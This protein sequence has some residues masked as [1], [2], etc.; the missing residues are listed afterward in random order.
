M[1][2]LSY[3]EIPILIKGGIMNYKVEST[4]FH[5]LFEEAD[6]LI[7]SIYF[8]TS[9]ISQNLSKNQIKLKNAISTIKE[10]QNTELFVKQLEVIMNDL[11]FWNQVRYG[12]A[13]LM[14][15][16]KNIVHF[17][18]KPVVTK[19]VVDSSPYLVPLIRHYQH[20]SEVQLLLVNRS[21]FKVYRGTV[22]KL[23]L[24]P[25]PTDEP[26]LAKDVLGEEQTQRYFGT[27]PTSVYHGGSNK[28]DEEAIDTVRYFKYVD[29]L[30]LEQYSKQSQLPLILVALPQYH[31]DFHKISEN[32]YLSKD[33]IGSDH[34]NSPVQVLQDE[35]KHLFEQETRQQLASL[36]DRFRTGQAN[37]M[38][39][40]FIDDIFQALFENRV[41]TLFI[42]NKTT[43]NGT[44][45]TP[46]HSFT[47]NPLEQH[48]LLMDATNLALQAKTK[49]LILDEDEMPTNH[50]LAVIMRY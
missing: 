43:L 40:D 1:I 11:S 38:A 34:I 15:P 10:Y 8:E 33:T 23:V 25:Y 12:L 36:R 22:D 24:E 18:S 42:Q 4:F 14:S 49:I 7:V 28:S 19:T 5:P 31:N 30:V 26:V 50:K 9:P 21:E 35:L 2:Q 44:I 29:K 13:I 37:G 17:L 27:S 41:D 45:D 48:D 46:N 32:P 20:L 16:T 3:Q 39:S 47:V 6:H